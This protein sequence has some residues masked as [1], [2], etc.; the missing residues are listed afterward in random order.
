MKRKKKKLS[1]KRILKIIKRKLKELWENILAIPKQT[2]IIIGIWTG[3]V[4][5]I[6]VLIIVGNSN[7]RF[8]EEYKS[9]ENSV[10]N[11]MLKYVTDNSFY[12]TVDAPIKMP[13]EILVDYGVDASSLEKHDCTGYSLYYYDDENETNEISSYIACADYVTSG[14]SSNNK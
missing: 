8:I 1:F 2:K 9:I 5:V 10:D 6:I 14:Y 12:G 3:I 4:L 7:K 11:A 13:V